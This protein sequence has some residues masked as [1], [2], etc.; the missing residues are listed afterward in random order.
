[1]DVDETKTITLEPEEAFRPRH[2]ELVVKVHKDIFPPDITPE[3]G[4]R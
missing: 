1:M 3:I 2:E 4:L